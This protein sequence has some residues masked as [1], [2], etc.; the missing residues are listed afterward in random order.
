[1]ATRYKYYIITGFIPTCEQRHGMFISHGLFRDKSERDAENYYKRL[2]AKLPKTRKQMEFDKTTTLYRLRY[3]IDDYILILRTTGPRDAVKAFD[4]LRYLLAL[5]YHK[6]SEEVKL[7]PLKSKPNFSST[8]S[9]DLFD[10]V[11]PSEIALNPTLFHVELGS[12]IHVSNREMLDI[13]PQLAKVFLQTNIRRALACLYQSQLTYYTHLVGS[14][15]EVHSRP[16]L[17][18][19]SRDEF[20]QHNFAYQEML[21]SSLLTCYRGIEALY[22]KNFRSD[23]FKKVNRSKL[24]SYMRTKIPNAPTKSRYRLR[25]YRQRETNPPR[26]KFIITMLEIL[27]RARNRAAHGYHWSRK[28]RLETFGSDLADES[29]FFLGHL[30]TCALW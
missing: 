23:D 24:E 15:V 19:M 7:V 2:R 25:F 17:I 18:Y 16:E 1:M 26:H 12:G 13:Q 6:Y 4:A 8:K 27:F 30:I 22:S 5:V 10:L 9:Q 11:M 14:Y 20:R 21:H 3:D 29:K 28:H